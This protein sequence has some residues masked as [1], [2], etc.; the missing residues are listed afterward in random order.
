MATDIK[1][2]MNL[3]CGRIGV[4]ATQE[5]AVE[6]AHYYGFG[7]VDPDPGYLAR[8]DDDDLAA[9]L[10]LLAAKKLVWAAA[11]VPVDFRRDEATFTEGM[12]KLPG[13]AKTLQRAGAD[14][15]GTWLLFGSDQLTSREFHRLMVGRI[16]AIA[17]VFG[18]HDLRFGL[19]YVGT[20]SAW[21]SVQFPW[22]HSMAEAKELIADV[23]MDNVGYVLDSWH[24]F[25]ALESGDDIR[26]LK[27]SDV[28]AVDVNDA[29]KGLDRLEMADTTRELPGATGVI[30][31][32]AFMTALQD[33]GYDGP[34]R[35]EP[36]NETLNQM[37]DDEAIAV[38]YRAMEKLW[39]YLK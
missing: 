38:V 8:L 7:S 31:A 30:D 24:W 23:G 4:R 26:T 16:R 22:V 20:K 35:A 6:W 39:G 12:G 19:E 37:A 13:V 34:V 36:F 2:T 14:R 1:M 3:S 25:H 11:G 28:V 15:A 27:A 5:E 17:E 32:A 33:I 9:F 10:E 21:T 29:P 18:E